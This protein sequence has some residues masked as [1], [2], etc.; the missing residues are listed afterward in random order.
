MSLIRKAKVQERA[1][2]VCRR[3][4]TDSVVPERD[5]SPDRSS[6]DSGRMCQSFQALRDG[7]SRC[8]PGRRALRYDYDSAALRASR[9]RSPARG[10]PARSTRVSRLPAGFIDTRSSC[11]PAA[12]WKAAV[13][14]IAAPIFLLVASIFGQLSAAEKAFTLSGAN[15]TLEDVSS[16]VEVRYRS[17]RLNRAQNVWNVEVTLTNKGSRVFRGPFV[18]LIDSFAGTTGP[19]QTEGVDDSTP[20]K[21]FYD[22]SNWVPDGTLASGTNSLPRTLSLGV[23]NGS[24]TLTTK[25]YAK[26]ASGYALGLTRSLNDVGQPLA[27]VQVVETGPQTIAT[28]QTDETLGLVTLGQTNG[29]HVWKFSAP[30]HLPVWR[31]A[32]LGGIDV[33]VLPNPRLTRRSSQSAVV[34]PVQGGQVANADGSVQITFLPGVLAQNGTAVLTPLTA[35]TL[36][37]LLPPGWSPLQAFW[38]ELTQE[39]ASPVTA[40]LRPWGPLNAGDTVA[41]ARWDAGALQ[42]IA[43]QLLTGNGLNAVTTSMP[44]SGAYCLVVADSGATAPLAPQAGQPLSFSTVPLP[45]S[46]S[47]SAA[48][49]VNPA[50]SPASRVAELVTASAQVIFTNQS[51]PLPSGVILRCEVMENYRLR[52]GSRRLLPQYENFIIGYQRPGDNDPRTLHASFPMRPLLLL[53]SDELEAATVSVDVLSPTP[54]GGGILDATGGQAV[55]EGIRLLAGTGD[56]AG[57]QA[58]QIRQQNP[59]NFSDLVFGDATIVQVFELSV[60]GMSPDRRLTAQFTGLPANSLFVLARVVSH[61]GLYGLE[62]RERLSTDANGNLTTR[63]PASGE[64]LPGVNSAGQYL[65]V[66]IGAPQGLVTGV[67]RN[68]TG[69]PAPDLP[70]R[71]VGQPW[72]TFSGAGGAFRLIA[73]VGNVD[74]AVTDLT[75]GDTGQTTVVVADPDTVVHAN[76]STA[77]VGPS[78]VSIN[79]TNAATL[80]SRVTPIVI[81]FSE[82]INPGSLGVGG[83]Q[84][85]GT[86]G[87]PVMASLTLNLRNTIATLLPTTQLAP[88]TLHTVRL[89]TN[90]ADFTS[91]KLEGANNFTFT[92]ESD[93]LDR[94]QTAQVVSYEPTNGVAV[95]TGS[96]GIAEPESPVILVNETTGRSATILSKPDGSFTNSIEAGVDDL[97]SA[98]IVNRNGTRNTIPVGRQIFRDGSVGLFNGGGILEA[99]SDGGPVQVFVEPGAIETKTKFKVETLSASA[100]LNLFSNTPPEGATVLGG[101]KLHATGDAPKQPVDISFPV[102]VA[103]LGLPPGANPEDASYALTVPREIDGE[104]VYEIVD[105]MHYENGKLVT[106]SLPFDGLLAAADVLDPLTGH[107]RFLEA[108]FYMMAAPIILSVGGSLTVSGKVLAVPFDAAGNPST[109]AAQVLRGA[110]VTFSP[111]SQAARPGRLRPG[112]LFGSSNSDGKYALLVPRSIFGGDSIT[113]R[114]SHPRFPGR[115]ARLPA[116]LPSFV[117]E[118]SLVDDWDLVFEID[119][120]DQSPPGMSISHAPLFPQPGSN[121]FLKVVATDRSSA[122][123]IEVTFDALASSAF[124]V[125]TVITNETV[126]A[127]AVRQ[128][129]F[130]TSTNEGRVVL[131]A[132]A[133]DDNGN[134][135]AQRYFVHFGGDNFSGENFIPRSD[136]NDTIPPQVSFTVPSQGSK[137]LQAGDPIVIKFNEAIDRGILNDLS[138]L[139]TEPA[140]GVPTG[141]LS[142]DQQELTLSFYDLAPNTAY[143]LSVSPAIR[144]LSGNPFDQYLETDGNN[145]YLLRFSTA[146]L[147]VGS[148][149][150]IQSGGGAIIKGNYGFVLERTGAM[151]G[152]VVVY[153]LSNPSLPRK[154]SEFSVP[155]YPRD[156]ALIPRYSYKRRLDGPTFDHDLLAVVGGKLG[157]LQVGQYLWVIDVTNPTNMQRVAAA[158]I[159]LSPTTAIK[160]VLWSPPQ[161]GYLE[162]GEVPSIGVIN[163]QTFILGSY[164]TTQ[165][166]ISLPAGGR[167]GTDLNFDGDYV[168]SG[169]ELPLPAPESRDVAG[170][171]FAFVLEDTDQFISDFDFEEGGEFV[172]VVVE[173]GHLFGAGGPT[174]TNVP[175]AYRTLYKGGALWDRTVASYPFTNGN[176]VRLTLIPQFELVRSNLV[177][178]IDLALVSLQRPSGETNGLALLDVTDPTSP[179]LISEIAVPPVHGPGLFGVTQREDGKLLLA[180]TRDLLLLDPRKFALSAP[181]NSLQSHPAIVGMVRGAGL[182]AQRI[183]SS[184]AG[185]TLAS[186]GNLNQ[187]FSSGP[188]IQVVEFQD[189]T[190]VFAIEQ[191]VNNSALLDELLPKANPVQQLYPARFRAET[192]APSTLSPPRP[193]G[194]YYL[195]VHASGGAGDSIEL[196]LESLNRSGHPLRNKGRGFPA[197]RAVGATALAALGQ[198]PVTD[199]EP[200]MQALTAF[201]LSSDK[202]D[203]RFNLYLSRP[204]ALVYERMTLEEIAAV[205]AQLPREILWGGFYLRASLDLSMQANPVLAPFATDADYGRQSL[206]PGISQVVETFPGGYLVGPNP[207]AAVG[208]TEVPGTFG[209]VSAHNGEFRTDTEDFV[210]PGRRINIEFVR[211]GMGQDLYDGPFGRFWDFNYNQQLQ[212][213]SPSVFPGQTEFPLVPRG[214]LQ[215]DIVRTRDVLFQTGD[216]G[217][218]HFRYVGSNAPPEIVADPLITSLGWR[219]RAADYYLPQKGF[220]VLLRFRDGKFARLT[221]G[222][223]QFW[224][225]GKGRLQAIYDRFPK[226]KLRFDYNLRDELVLIT[227][228]SVSV[229]RDLKLGYWRFA[230]DPLFEPA[231]DRSTTNSYIAGKI[232]RL[233]DYTGRDVLFFYTDE[234]LLERREGPEVA[235]LGPDGFAG[236]PVTRYVWDAACGTLKGIIAGSDDGTPLL[237]ATLD[238][239]SETP[240][241]KGAQGAAGPVELTFEHANTA[242]AVASGTAKTTIKAADGS[243]TDIQFNAAGL[244][245]TVV[246]R[247]TNVPTSTSSHDYNDDDLMTRSTT[248]EGDVEEHIYDST[249]PIWRSRGNLLR[250]RRIPGPRGGD[251][252]E[253]RYNYDPRFNLSSGVQQNA[254]GQFSTHVLS[255]NGAALERIDYPSAGSQTFAYNEHG[256]LQSQRTLEGFEYAFEYDS[257]TGFRTRE[258]RGDIAITYLYEGLSGARG[259]ETKVIP[260]TNAPITFTYDALERLMEE[261]R[262]G[263]FERFAYDQNGNVIR[264]DKSISTNLVLTERR[265]YDQLGFLREATME[266]VEV[267]GSPTN[268]VTRYEPDAQQRIKRVLYPGGEVREHEFDQLGR[269]VRTRTGEQEERY[270]Y[271]LAGNLTFTATGSSSNTYLYDGHNRPLEIR[272]DG[273]AGTELTRMTYFGEGAVKSVTIDDPVAGRVKEDHIDEIDSYGRVKRGRS[274]S[275]SHGYLTTEFQYD[276]AQRRIVIINPRGFEEATYYDNAGRTTRRVT[277]LAEV[278]FTYDGNDNLRQV[279]SIEGTNTYTTFFQFDELDQQIETSDDIGLIGRQTR[280]VDGVPLRTENGRGYFIEQE[281]SILGEP[282][283]TREPSGVVLHQHY[284]LHRTLSKVFDAVGRGKSYRYDA[285]FRISEV[286]NRNGSIVRNQVFDPRGQ[287]VDMLIPGGDVKA[288]Y[289]SQQR[290]TNQVVTFNGLVRTN[291]FNRDALGRTARIN[292]NGDSMSFQFDTWGALLAA[293]YLEKGREHHVAAEIYPDGSRKSLAYPSGVTV[294]EDRGADRRLISLTTAGGEPLIQSVT[295]HNSEQPAQ[296]V[297][298]TNLFVSR[299]LYD[300]RKR[301]MALRYEKPSGEILVDIRYVYDAGDNIVARQF[302]HRDGR[303][304]LFSYDPADRL[305]RADYGARPGISSVPRILSGFTPPADV[306]GFAPGFFARQYDYD[307]NGLDLLTQALTINPDVLATPFFV[308]NRHGHDDFLFPTNLD[309]RLR[310]APDALGNTRKH[311]LPVPGLGGVLEIVSADLTHDGLGHLSRVSMENGKVIEYESRPDGTRYFRRV[312]DG[313]ITTEEAGFIYYNDL[314][315]EE[316]NYLGGTNEVTARYYYGDSDVPFAADLKV[317]SGPLKRHWFLTDPFGSVVAVLN[318][319]GEMVEQVIYDP[320]AQPTFEPADRAPPRVARIES[321]DADL[322]VQ[323]SEPV[324]PALDVTTFAP[325]IVQTYP[326]LGNSVRFETSTALLQGEFLLDE[327]R[328]PLGAWFRFTPASPIAPGT[329][330]TL[331][332]GGNALR[333]TWRNANPVE[334]IPILAV[335]GTNVLFDAGLASTAPVSTN[336]SAV[337]LRLLFHGQ[338]FDRETGLIYLRRRY[339]DPSSGIFL[340]PDPEGYSDS[341]NPYAAFNHNPV[342]ERDPS[343][344]ISFKWLSNLFKRG[345]P[346]PIVIYSRREAIL[347]AGFHELEREAITFA[348]NEFNRLHAAKGAGKS[349]NAVHIRNPNAY[350]RVERLEQGITQKPGFANTKSLKEGE[351]RGLIVENGREYVGDLDLHSI[352]INGRLATK[353]EVLEFSTI[354]NRRFVEMW[355]KS[356][357]VVKGVPPVPFKHGA[358][359][360]FP[361]KLGEMLY[362]AESAGMSHI[363][364]KEVSP[365]LLAKLGHPGSSTMFTWDARGRQFMSLTPDEVTRR[366]AREVEPKLIQ[367]QRKWNRMRPDRAIGEQGFSSIDELIENR[368]NQWMR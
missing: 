158:A 339:Y 227:D 336:R 259:L 294:L 2:L 206:V 237:Q 132:K 351:K 270:G 123:S 41:L 214:G 267:D 11:K 203:P 45:Q 115:T 32:A 99:Q 284:A 18:L 58:V 363:G 289:D 257:A 51:G 29:Q 216:G 28:H 72:L 183:A 283:R 86:N 245:A 135:N 62:P 176:P 37:A 162:I 39:P 182:G 192:G 59:T 230:A 108:T 334:T 134:T 357:R 364:A 102:D 271:D 21:R 194:H 184:P 112:T 77:A 209:S 165:E 157:Q 282:T 315:L 144:D 70:L 217:N 150:D 186:L 16:E 228:E 173:A 141:V 343:G 299:T 326:A 362:H 342:N 153:D 97:L 146:P 151:D 361:E 190:N 291:A 313:G 177:S 233:L 98:V 171:V 232:A 118:G 170:K 266:N 337:D 49:S 19:L 147:P 322:F 293:H 325:G 103:G 76:P 244:P 242:A 205:K 133:T 292:Y 225:S 296:M 344:T 131:L 188:S 243:F 169:E 5:R 81:Q 311:P 156:F 175:A 93:A 116:T 111:S 189:V 137:G 286:T 328:K 275:S 204:F 181:T 163:L 119:S 331:Q 75:T 332:V 166:F 285:S 53:G 241:I 185:L 191:L 66:R 60:A 142:Q 274:L 240:Q 221:P 329:A 114:A 20:A 314:L 67:A 210:L 174:E 290:L 34:T 215:E 127:S 61:D 54:F 320:W 87:Q 104:T 17:M 50:S 213:L 280:R 14:W 24:P 113:L 324:H 261:R 83:I 202:S 22:L 254:N 69:Q 155:G 273:G 101:L 323:F 71:I 46:S 208:H 366:L 89:S 301:P 321:T 68:S 7:R 252:L 347:R 263:R 365:D 348:R 304:D 269:L 187:V 307:T 279:R 277:P 100:F 368:Q 335:S 23:T 260:P 10:D 197:V 353:E 358:H 360:N 224:Y 226:N 13:R 199:C 302:V 179:I 30:D 180:T 106:H 247:G 8:A 340:Q 84:L 246:L 65:L 306:S 52:D 91:R 207:P 121:A 136:P 78:V 145:P 73:P 264:V 42:W 125:V 9:G 168:D 15:L 350:E 316:R 57:I 56:L 220:D 256:Q 317:G 107:F 308:T 218:V 349:I 172:S 318:D 148:L 196:A 25:V 352:E 74:V 44:G 79:P 120:E 309:G 105:R 276:S 341:V 12:A 265:R 195:L 253:T 82:P 140:G 300:L 36:P 80:V 200:P 31:T 298:G 122:P 354:A 312:S 345:K 249:N 211:T 6:P 295:Y 258:Y 219:D 43:V 198:S 139:Q 109:N 255:A 229:R 327:T 126:G 138:A 40:S 201:R 278:V 251:T 346:R 85:L 96:P 63:E 236:R 164:F 3:S 305:T 268:L 238:T 38:L 297:Y 4:R 64:R 288:G 338:Y 223:S 287:P 161:L 90:I 160:K 110:R 193:E 128:T 333:D 356:G 367:L 143:T 262:G 272:R 48:G 152:G 359:L 124:A 235:P 47:L 222:G 310:G 250:I 159:N 55:L 95:M 129:L 330:L 281:F 231:V 234:G 94:I 92:T 154:V 239:S 178:S 355:K 212:Q 319:L 35:Q 88:S 1:S 303:A 248:P 33:T 26:V 117:Q 130:V 167:E 149:Q 27:G